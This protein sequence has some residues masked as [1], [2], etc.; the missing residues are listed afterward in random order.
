MFRIRSACQISVWRPHHFK[1]ECQT[2]PSGSIEAK[3]P[4]K[5]PNKTI[6]CV[7]VDDWCSLLKGQILYIFF[8][9]RQLLLI[10]IITQCGL[11]VVSGC[12]II[13]CKTFFACCQRTQTNHFHQLE[14]ATSSD[15]QWMYPLPCP[16][17]RRWHRLWR[18]WMGCPNHQKTKTH[19][20]S[21]YGW[22]STILTHWGNIP[23]NTSCFCTVYR[24]A[25]AHTTLL[26][27]DA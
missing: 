23:W 15:E 3:P 10:I 9:S 27:G 2:F 6:S 20:F 21:R 25:E 16:P 26:Q 19:S 12:S 24:S 13:K 5:P 18:F 8:S 4:Q 11:T 1:G 17:H 22:T 14:I 7:E